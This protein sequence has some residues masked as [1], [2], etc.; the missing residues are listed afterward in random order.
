MWNKRASTVPL[1]G[2]AAALAARIGMEMRD[3]DEATIRVVTA[4]AGLLA[5]VAYADRDYS[6]D[7]EARV[8]LELGRIAG[9]TPAGIDAICVTLREHVVEISTVEAPRYCRALLELGDRELRVEVLEALTELAATDGAITT[10][11]TNWLRQVTKALGLTQ[12]D[13]NSAQAKHRERL[14]VLSSPGRS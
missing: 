10:L 7:E 2:G 1:P 12:D 4:L 9:M 13:Y 6:E 5:A 8:R 3:A 14:S 11:E